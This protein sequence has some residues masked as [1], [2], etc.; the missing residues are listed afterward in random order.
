MDKFLMGAPIG[1]PNRLLSGNINSLLKLT[2]AVGHPL[3]AHQGL[4]FEARQNTK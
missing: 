4:T 3:E 1:C 2:V